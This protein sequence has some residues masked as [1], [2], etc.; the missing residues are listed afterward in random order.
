M[1]IV[2]FCIGSS[3]VA[4]F[5]MTHAMPVPLQESVTSSPDTT[6]MVTVYPSSVDVGGGQVEASGGRVGS[7]GR[8]QNS[9]PTPSGEG[10]APA[11]FHFLAA[12][13]IPSPNTPSILPEIVYCTMRS[14]W[15]PMN[16]ID[17][18]TPDV[19][20]AMGVGVG[21]TVGIGTGVG[22]PADGSRVC[23]EQSFIGSGVGVGVTVGI[24]TGVGQPADGSR[25]CL[26]QSFI[27]SGMGV[28]VT[29]GIG[30]GVGQPADGSRVCLEQS[31]IGSGMG[32]AVDA[33]LGVAVSAGL[34]VAV[35]IVSGS[36]HGQR[37]LLLAPTT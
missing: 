25:V 2:R 6:L 36:H 7:S 8:W 34:G 23:L 16:A 29:V 22:Q 24:G 12:V 32:V 26:E 35:H 17:S 28:G 14:D 30:T 3:P 10:A 9:K 13:K 31:F 21:V 4:S 1:I 5:G 20:V 19:G 27:G 11:A 37:T 15:R 33:G 18:S